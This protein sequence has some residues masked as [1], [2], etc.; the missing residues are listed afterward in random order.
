MSLPRVVAKQ[1]HG[2]QQLL[3]VFVQ[4]LGSFSNLSPPVFGWACSLKFRICV[5][6]S[7]ASRSQVHGAGVCHFHKV[8]HLLPK[9]HIVVGKHFLSNLLCAIRLPYDIHWITSKF[10][11]AIG[12]GG[13]RHP[14][15]RVLCS[16]SSNAVRI[17]K[18]KKCE[19][20]INMYHIYQRYINT[21]K[22]IKNRS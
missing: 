3:L 4:I 12:W 17:Q 16:G 8:I 11:P 6:L 21:D 22:A 14:K 7:S 9:W 2:I 19:C 1:E 15:M 5:I 13:P 18:L 10:S 20:M